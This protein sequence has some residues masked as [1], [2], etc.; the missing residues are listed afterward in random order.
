VLLDIE[1]AGALAPGADVVVY[2]ASNTDRGFLDALSTAVHAQPAPTAV[3]IGWGQSEDEWTRQA[4]EYDAG[5]GW[6]A[7]TGL[8]VPDGQALL[9]RLRTAG[10]G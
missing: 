7:C 4:G 6:D 5:P 3:S 8:G 9:A 10:N 1:V 2:F